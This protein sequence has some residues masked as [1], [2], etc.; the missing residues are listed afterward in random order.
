MK[1]WLIKLL[2]I[3]CIPL[4]A[5]QDI[6]TY[7]TPQKANSGRILKLK[8]VMQIEGQGDDYYYSYASKLIIDKSGNIYIRDS[9]QTKSHLLKFSPIGKFLK[10]LYRQGEGPGEI[11]SSY[12]FDISAKEVFVFDHTRKKIILMELD[13]KFIKE[14]KPKSVR[15]SDFV[16]LYKD[17]L[18]FIRS[19]W[20]VERKTSR[21]YDVKN[22]IV[23]ISKDGQIEKEFYNFSRKIF[24][25]SLA[26]GGG[27]MRWD[28]FIY[29]ISENK[30]F[31]CSSREYI[32]EVLDLDLGKII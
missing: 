7:D 11:Q 5:E 17:W 29:V 10:D 20:P 21:L 2:L 4:N 12:N 1:K 8:E 9:W 28:P 6:L 16:G 30:L 18:V 15:L 32:I 24:L 22:V 3:L 14:F 23:F 25:I 19:D 31:V 26:Q 27:M 13:G